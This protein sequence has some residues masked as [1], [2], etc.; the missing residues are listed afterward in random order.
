M[1]AA[2]CTKDLPTETG[3]WQLKYFLFSPRTLGKIPILIHIFQMGWF[4]HQLGKNIMKKFQ[5]FLKKTHIS[6]TPTKVLKHQILPKQKNL[7]NRLYRPSSPQHQKMTQNFWNCKKKLLM[8]LLSPC[9]NHGNLLFTVRSRMFKT[10]VTKVT[11]T[12]RKGS[13]V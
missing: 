8:H 1:S 10:S 6:N 9:C 3:W 11:P 13:G 2:V 12:C 4:N 7:P 5:P